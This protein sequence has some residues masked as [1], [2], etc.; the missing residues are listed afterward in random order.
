MYPARSDLSTIVAGSPARYLTDTETLRLTVFNAAASVRVSLRARK[1]DREGCTKPSGNEKTPT[2]DRTANVVDVKPG[3]GWLVGAAAILVAGAPGDG[4]TYVV[5]SIGIGDGANFTETE[6]LASGTITAAK[7]VSWPDSPMLGPLDSPGALRSIA[8]TSP[9]AGAEITETV[10]TGARWEVIA[11]GAR[12]TA[13]AAAANRFP[14]LTIDD[15]GAVPYIDEGVLATAQTAN[16]VARYTWREGLNAQINQINFN[17]G[18]PE[19][20][21]IPAASRIK[22]ITT[23]IQAGDQWDQVQYLV[24]ERIEGA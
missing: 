9:G 13:S 20:T 3:E 12:F 23:G 8:G 15:G 2:T 1:V 16:Q 7:R 5:L 19:L 11:F 21:A 17:G 22:T 10:P 24:R 6:V 14:R 18:L 4:L